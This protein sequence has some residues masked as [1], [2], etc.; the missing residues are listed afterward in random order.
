MRILIAEDDPGVLSVL[1][2]G[3]REEGY[4]LDTAMRGDDA[5][6]LL[7]MYDY[8]AAIIDWRLPGLL[9]DEVIRQARSHH[10]RTAM[11]MLT[12]RDT[13][14]DKVTGLD[15]GA[16]DYLVKPVAFPELLARLRALLRRPRAGGEPVLEIGALRLDPGTRT[17]FSDSHEIFLTARE[18][19]ILELLMRRS[20]AVVERLT[21]ARHAWDDES[22]A[23]GSN[24]IDVHVGHVRRKL[25]GTG[26]EVLTVRGTGYRLVSP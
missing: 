9:G 6:E 21:I 13:T 19:A 17:V 11:L 15:A 16:D 14:A 7:R 25:A 8:A 24:T 26:V 23:V 5:L 1:A 2:R 12:A 20:P 4:V 18:M 22:D 10:V 3:L